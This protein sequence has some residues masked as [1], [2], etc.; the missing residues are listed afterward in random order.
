[1]TSPPDSSAVKGSVPR[2]DSHASFRTTAASMIVATRGALRSSR[3]AAATT[4]PWSTPDRPTYQ[5]TGGRE[6]HRPRST[7]PA[8]TSATIDQRLQLSIGRKPITTSPRA[9]RFSTACP[10]PRCTRW[11][12]TRRHICP[13]AICSRSNRN[14]TL[15]G[16][17]PASSPSTT[18]AS[19]AKTTRS[20][21]TP[22]RA[23]SGHW[24]GGNPD[25]ITADMHSSAAD[26]ARI[27]K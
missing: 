11:P 20:G 14:S 19:T 2:N 9:A 13:V 26:A 23:P 18:P 3:I 27:S 12:V 15:T 17:P 1:M 21:Q 7:D 8:A 6:N 25:I 10:Q 22:C 24:A 16:S 4:S 5:A